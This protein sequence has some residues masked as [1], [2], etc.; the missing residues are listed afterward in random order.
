MIWLFSILI[1]LIMALFV[2]R[3][4]PVSPLLHFLTALSALPC[5]VLSLT[6]LNIPHSYFNSL[7]MGSSFGLDQ[8][9]QVFLFF[10]SLLYMVSGIYSYS[11]F[12][13]REDREKRRFLFFFLLCMCGNLGLF[14]AQD[15]VTFYAFFTLMAV[16]AYGLINYQ[17]TPFQAKAG[18]IYIAMTLLGEGFLLVA[19]VLLVAPEGNLLLSE[20]G[21]VI[22]SSPHTHLIITLLVLGFGV[23]CA[24]IPLHIWLPLAYSAAAAPG[25]AVLAGAMIKAGLFGWIYFLPL[26]EIGLPVWS[27]VL[28]TLGLTGAFYGVVFGLIH[29]APKTILG[30]SSISQMGLITASVGIALNQ[31]EHSELIVSLIVLYALNH[32]LAKGALFIGVDLIKGF[33]KSFQHYIVFVG[34]LLASFAI[35]G[36]PFLGGAEIK[37]A[38]SE[39]SELSP[40]FFPVVLQWV[41]PLSALGTA[42]LFAHF[43]L[44]IWKQPTKTRGHHR[45][46][47]LWAF[48]FLVLLPVPLGVH[49]VIPYYGIDFP[50]DEFQTYHFWATVW[51][52]ILAFILV[53]LTTR[54]G[55]I[56]GKASSKAPRGDVLVIILKPVEKFVELLRR[57][58]GSALLNRKARLGPII[59]PFIGRDVKYDLMNTLENRV[60]SWSL[61]GVIFIL[62]ILV[63]FLLL[64]SF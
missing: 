18:V 28:I 43:L 45:G 47:G 7:L 46:S 14:L 49:I 9:R 17:G 26:G 15:V 2:L 64:F 35:I 34:L 16:S 29:R 52:I 23:K 8:T 30:Y 62:L 48:V 38:L 53:W 33:E 12:S 27:S 25:S 55:V 56:T 32:G 58:S 59:K 10:S 22:I 6:G 11:F 61:A 37:R 40:A 57:L 60:T 19:M 50:I 4:G 20:T 21:S 31:L 13:G 44:I 39:V 36:A 54:A 1:P 51:P 63:F 5:L 3:P 42:C 24:V 41:L